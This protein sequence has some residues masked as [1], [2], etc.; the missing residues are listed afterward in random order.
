MEK[1]RHAGTS[2]E[3]GRAWRRWSKES[4]C[5]FDVSDGSRGSIGQGRQG[6]ILARGGVFLGFVIFLAVGGRVLRAKNKEES[7]IVN[8]T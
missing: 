7:K 2:V 4:E 5:N 3:C 1:I 6:T 8:R